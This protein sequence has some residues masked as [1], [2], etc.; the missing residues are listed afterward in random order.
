MLGEVAAAPVPEVH[1]EEGDFGGRVDPAERGIELHAVDQQRLWN[2]V[3]EPD[4][5]ESDVAMAIDPVGRAR[6]EVVGARAQGAVPAVCEVIDPGGSND[7]ALAQALDAGLHRRVHVGPPVRFERDLQPMRRME[8]R[9]HA[10]G[11]FEV[12]RF[13]TTRF[14]ARQGIGAVGKALHHDRVLMVSGQRFRHGAQLPAPGPARHRRHAEVHARGES[15]IQG[16]LVEA[17]PVPGRPRA[18]VHEAEIDGLAQLDRTGRRQE[19]VREMGLDPL[20][21][22]GGTGILGVGGG[23]SQVLR[24]PFREG[25]EAGRVSRH[26]GTGCRRRAGGRPT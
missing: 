5:L 11:G 15:A 3:E 20:D 7:G 12:G 23:P 25:L 6:C 14:E 18:E 13:Q 10:S 17:V 2:I 26:G 4:V 22:V 9:E 24:E 8:P 19:D 1:G 21:A 16:D